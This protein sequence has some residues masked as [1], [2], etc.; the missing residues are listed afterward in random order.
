MFRV[1]QT[2]H[3]KR[4]ACIR[5]QHLFSVLLFMLALALL[6]FVIILVFSGLRLTLI[7]RLDRSVIAV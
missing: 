3:Y 7:G 5:L 2:A 4:R 1:I 6:L